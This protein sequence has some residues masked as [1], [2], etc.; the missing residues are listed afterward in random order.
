MKKT[1]VEK[2]EDSFEKGNSFLRFRA[3]DYD[4]IPSSRHLKALN[5]FEETVKLNPNHHEAW[6][7]LSYS[8]E[9]Y[10]TD[11]KEVFFFEKALESAAKAVETKPNYKMLITK[12]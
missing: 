7:N 12:E 10:S 9:E 2:A 6:L 5:R 8:C 4:Y 1:D 11:E 3:S